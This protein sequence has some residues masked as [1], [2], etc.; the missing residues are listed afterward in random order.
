MIRSDTLIKVLLKDVMRAASASGYSIAAVIK[1]LEINVGFDTKWP[2]RY[3]GG[4]DI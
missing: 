2:D 1:L 4:L 3:I